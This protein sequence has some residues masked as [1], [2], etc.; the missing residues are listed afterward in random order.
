[1]YGGGE[2]KGYG[3]IRPGEQGGANSPQSS[4]TLA[5]CSRCGPSPARSG[6]WRRPYS[7]RCRRAAITRLNPMSSGRPSTKAQSAG[8]SGRDRRTNWHND[9]D[10]E[11]Q[12]QVAPGQ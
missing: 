7:R 5:S 12:D 9:Q 3:V 11:G 6:W 2:L 8:N 1:M 4:I 10:G